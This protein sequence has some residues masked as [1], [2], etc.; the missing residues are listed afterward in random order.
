MKKLLL[1]GLISTTFF[2]CDKDDEVPATIVY[3]TDG[4]PL[5]MEKKALLLMGYS[6]GSA[7]TINYEIFRQLSEA[8]YGA[9]LNHLS[10][11]IVEGNIFYSPEAD[12]IRTNFLSLTP[13]SFVVDFEEVSGAE[14]FDA[15]ESSIST[16]PLLSVAHK[17]SENDT[18]WI[19]DNKVKFF[20]DTSSAG[21]YI[22][23]YML[24][25]IRAKT[26][27]GDVNLNV[28]EVADLTSRKDSASFWA[29]DVMS[30]DSTKNVISSGDEYY[31]QWVLMRGFNPKSAWG[32]Q[33]GSYWPFGGEFFRGD[34]IGT[35]D[36]PI[37]HHFL[38]EPKLD[39]DDVEIPYDF[40]PQFITVVW[41]L[42]PFT[43][44]YEYVNSYA[45]D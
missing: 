27:E 23:T 10:L 12:T 39:G 25:R 1:I 32:K 41:A 37:R 36:T 22:E 7:A 43:S 2:A 18:A 30:L 19:V 24:G 15:I 13:P 14:V 16:A 6:S 35:R 8:E 31:H 28:A 34:V 45:T 20:Q 29:T 17:V 26:Y 9:K 40:E 3:T 44:A 38:K 11:G 21:I 42:N 33:L 5:P 4:L